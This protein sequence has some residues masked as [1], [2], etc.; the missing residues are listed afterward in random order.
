[1]NS[2][3]TNAAEKAKANPE[4]FLLKDYDLKIAYLSSHFTRMWN[5]FNYFVAIETALVGAKFLIPN[6]AFS[7]ALTIAGVLI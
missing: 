7:P 5:R 4:A 1:M 6:W 3:Q 2:D